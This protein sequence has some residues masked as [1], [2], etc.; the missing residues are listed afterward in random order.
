[1]GPVKSLKK[2]ITNRNIIIGLAEKIFLS[3]PVS[4]F[5]IKVYVQNHQ[6][7]MAFTMI[8]G[9]VKSS[10]PDPPDPHVFGP[11]GSGSEF[12]SQRYGSGSFCHQ[13]KM[14]RKIVIPT[15]L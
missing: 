7:A 6:T 5:L 12:T 11:S 15:V 8:W 14:V 2:L 3:V 10:V 4:L 1:L 9:Q 13:A